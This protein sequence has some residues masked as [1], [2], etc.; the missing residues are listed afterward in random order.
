MVNEKLDKAKAEVDIKFNTLIEFHKAN[1]EVHTD[2]IA[3][4]MGKA[5]NEFLY[6]LHTCKMQVTV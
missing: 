4:A 3:E 1:N 2:A 6:V 5:L